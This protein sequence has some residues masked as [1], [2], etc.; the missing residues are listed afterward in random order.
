MN[1]SVIIC[2]HNPHKVYLDRTLKALKAQTLSKD[3]WEL[4]LIDNA[5]TEPISEK[6][7][8]TWHPNA[9]HI[10]ESNLGLLPARLRGIKESTADLLV[11]VDDDN[12]LNSEYLK[13]ALEISISH[14]WV[15]AFGGNIVGEFEDPPPEWLVDK[16]NLLAIVPAEN[17][18]WAFGAG[19][20]VFK[21]CPCGAGMVIRSQIAKRYSLQAATDPLRVKLGRKGSSLASA[22]DS[23]MGLTSCLLGFA[24]GHFPKLRL[25]HLISSN[26]VQLDY[27]LKL[28]EEMVFS[29]F[30]LQYVWDGVIPERKKEI[31]CTSEK[32]F[33]AYKEF[34]TRRSKS[35]LDEIQRRFEEAWGRGTS[36]AIEVLE[37]YRKLSS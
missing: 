14:P 24:V 10:T 32:I 31:Y 29:Y 13:N 12:V 19:M 23:D 21:S 36:K 11:F 4:L 28:S 2:S 22:E 8:L 35:P 7:E 25:V 6:C 34:R 3:Q 18:E 27:I 26:R 37:S 20:S 15:G 9:R 5:S 17:E 1:L 33:R 16:L 30:I